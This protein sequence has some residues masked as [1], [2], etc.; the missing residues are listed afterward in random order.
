MTRYFLRTCN[1]DMTSRNDFKWPTKGYV[2]APDWEPTEKCGNGL[3]GFLDGE[4]AGHLADWS[5][6]AK[7][8]VGE[9]IGDHIYLGRKIK[10]RAANVLLTGTRREA[11]DFLQSL[12]VKG[13]IMG[14]TVTGGN[15]ATVTGG[16]FATVTGGYQA[17]VIGGDYAIVTGGDF[18]TVT[19]GFGSIVTGGFGAILIVKRLNMYRPQ[20]EVAYVGEDGIKSNTPYKFVDG[21]FIEVK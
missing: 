18:A 11:T 20:F 2:E 16:D 13:A 14:A 8:L 10:F 17:K 21:K 1:A 6:E 19:G 3:H 12:G 15:F 4:G 5:P 9:I 7:W